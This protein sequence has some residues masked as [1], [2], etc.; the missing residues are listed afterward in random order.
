VKGGYAITFYG[1]ALTLLAVSMFFD[2]ELLLHLSLWSAGIFA[3]IV[4]VYTA[5]LFAQAK[6]RDFWQS[7][8]L[9]L[10][11]LIH[12][13]LAGAAVFA[14]TGLMGEMTADWAG[15]LKT[16]MIS[17][18]AL[19]LLTIWVELTITHPTQEAKLTV[20]MIT[21]GRYAGLFR[22]GVLLVGNILPLALLLTGQAWAQPV[23][24]LLALAGIYM[25]EKIWVE[26]P[27]RIQLS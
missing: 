25:T 18:I 6:G 15:Y 21:K 1:L 11:M 7:P 2:L 14:L 22:W 10:H 27:Q 19:N 8:A 23:A 13:L 12:S 26:A 16:M 4:A 24:G 20:K 5:F 17:M 3:V 9:A